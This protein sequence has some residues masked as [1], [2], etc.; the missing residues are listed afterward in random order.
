MNILE[1]ETQEQAQSAL[2]VINKI[3][4][5]WWASQG[6]DVVDDETSPSGKKVIGVSAKTGEPRPD[7]QG[8]TTWAT[9]EESPVGTFYFT[10]LTDDPRFVDWRDYLPEG[11]QMPEDK[12]YP[13]E[14][15]VEDEQD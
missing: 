3:A 11:V 2:A 12:P 14:W 6:F 9:I 5:G 1:F 8:T 7:A 10:T 15:N 4:A 13:E